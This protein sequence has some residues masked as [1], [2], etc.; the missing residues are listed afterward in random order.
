[1]RFTANSFQNAATGTRSNLFLRL[2]VQPL[3]DRSES[4][5][6]PLQLGLEL[7]DGGEIWQD[8]PDPLVDGVLPLLERRPEAFLLGFAAGQVVLLRHRGRLAGVARFLR[9]FLG[10]QAADGAVT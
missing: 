5:G 9:M 2:L 8:R 4:V 10:Y 1:G 6:H 7:T 3:F